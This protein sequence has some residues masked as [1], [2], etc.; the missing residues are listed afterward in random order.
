MHLNPSLQE[1]PPAK[2][3]PRGAAW[4]SVQQS[5]ALSRWALALET[6][7]PAPSLGQS[8]T[9]Y[10]PGREPSACPVPLGVVPTS[11]R[12]RLWAHTAVRGSEA[13]ESRPNL[14]IER[15]GTEPPKETGR[16]GIPCQRPRSQGRQDTSSVS[17]ARA[18]RPENIPPHW[19]TRFQR[20]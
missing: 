16:C 15:E 3:K 19:D 5:T 10:S 14:Q 6:P 1:D 9:C 20:G 12:H 2:G 18:Q 13:V 7:L 17:R 11:P 4:A 8:D